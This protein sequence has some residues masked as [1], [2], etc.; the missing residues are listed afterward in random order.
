MPLVFN[1]DETCICDNDEHP[2]KAFTPIE[3]TEGGMQICLRDEQSK[4]ASSPIEVI[5]FDNCI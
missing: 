2:L 3:V 5:R 1:E 4:K